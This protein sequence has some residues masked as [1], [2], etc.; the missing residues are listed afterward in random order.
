MDTGPW[1][2]LSPLRRLALPCETTPFFRKTEKPQR[3][4]DST[5]AAVGAGRGGADSAPGTVRG[6]L[7]A[8]EALE[9]VLG[10]SG[11]PRLQALEATVDVLLARAQELSAGIHTHAHRYVTSR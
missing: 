9:A 1:Y 8:A 11:D 4:L 6:A 7:E 3:R 2:R 5:D 10:G